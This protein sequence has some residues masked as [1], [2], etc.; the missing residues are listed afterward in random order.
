MWTRLVLSAVIVLTSVVVVPAAPGGSSCAGLTALTIPHV[1]ITSGVE[2]PAG[3]FS[4]TAGAAAID[5]PSFCRVV[6][7]A[8]PVPESKITFEVWIPPAES[9]N[10]KFQGVGNSGWSG[11]IAYGSMA[12]A[13][14]RGYAT[15]STDA[16]HTGDDVVF[17][18]GAP[19]KVVD[20][21]YRAIHV[22][23]GASKEIVRANRGSLPKFSY[24]TG[25]STAGA[26]GLT[27]AQRF[28]DDYD[29]ILSANPGNE[30]INRLAGYIWSWSAAH[31]QP[32]TPLSA[33]QLTAL[34]KAAVAACDAQDGVSDGVIDDPR[35]CRFDPVALQC[36]GSEDGTC[37]TSAQVA[38]VRKIYD[39]PKHPRTGERLFP[40]VPRGSESFGAG[41]NAGWQ[42]YI[43]G[44]D[45]PQRLGFWK[46]FVFDDPNWDFRTFDWDR[47]LAFARAKVGAIVDATNPDL[48]PFQKSGGKILMYAGWNDPIHL[49]EQ[50]LNYY[51]DVTRQS[52]GAAAT[53]QFFRLF[54]VPGLGHCAPGPGPSTFDAL[55]ALEAWV[56]K[57]VA[58]EKIIASRTAPGTPPRTRPL[59]PYPQVARWSGSGSSD[60]AANF[61]CAAPR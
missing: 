50:A 61:T 22:M 29:G 56:E 15:A 59:C 11:T 52:G 2:V 17:A 43:M 19:E 13:L 6:A 51:E 60:D 23:T 7:V 24:F 58:P 34:N 30:R 14:R 1:R 41:A 25:C 38:G 3:A 20:W 53:R 27:A 57:G 16:G 5:V 28:P 26:Q 32:G 45:E 18:A 33:A 35:K 10:G 31:G 9:W 12:T 4:P 54:M 48:R 47:D 46:H 21:A 42:S 39:G 37:L 44:P 40:G 55:A 36:K 49:S 8:S